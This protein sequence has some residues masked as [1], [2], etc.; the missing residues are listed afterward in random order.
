MRRRWWLFRIFDWLLRN[1]P[2]KNQRRGLLVIRMD[3]IG[4]MVL[5]R[6]SLDQYSDE[7]NVPKNDIQ[8]LGCK[9]WEA[10]SDEA[11]SGYRV[12]CID[13]HAYA[14]RLIYRIW[15]N[16]RVRRWNVAITVCDA[17]FRRA[18]M[19]DS[20]AYV[21]SAPRTI[22]ALPYINGDTHAEFSWYLG[23]VSDV[24]DTGPYPRHEIERHA[25][26]VGIPIA[27]IGRIGPPH[28]HATTWLAGT[29]WF[30]LDD[31]GTHPGERLG[32]GRSR[33][34]LRH[35]ED[36]NS[37]QS[38]HRG[39]SKRDIGLCQ[40]RNARAECFDTWPMISGRFSE[41]ITLADCDQGTFRIRSGLCLRG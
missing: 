30:H 36:A 18:L 31:I 29:R 16:L 38:R 3:G 21:A 15:V 34:V 10:V 20:L 28:H 9:S 35:V 13:E 12:F 32:A 33:F 2:V 40:L 17:Y 1:L 41:S 22:M 4:D 24:I 25:A 26:L 37:V 19:A 14:K 27:E 6:N 5:F 39:T 8:V 11:F 23:Q 7:F